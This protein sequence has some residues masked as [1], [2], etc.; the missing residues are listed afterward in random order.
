MSD[1]SSLTSPEGVL[2][3]CIAVCLDGI[4]FL[5]FILGTWFAIDDYGT[6]DMIGVMLIG[7]WM[8]TRGDGGQ[9]IKNKTKEVKD[10]AIDKTKEVTKKVIETEAKNVVKKSGWRFLCVTIGEFI[11]F[12]GGLMPFWTWFVWKELG[13]MSGGG[14]GSQQEE[15]EE[16][17]EESQEKASPSLPQRNTTPT[18]KNNSIAA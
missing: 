10:K 12:L 8:F 11:P 15:S 17:E 5:I 2:M 1:E 18:E 6:V 13:G 4:G 14:G 16:G 3:L 7:G 9:T